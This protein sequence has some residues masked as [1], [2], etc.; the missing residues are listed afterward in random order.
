[1]IFNYLFFLFCGFMF[2][3][4]HFTGTT[5]NT[6][7]WGVLTIINRINMLRFEKDKS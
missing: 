2:M 7:F 5:D 3:Y 1:M 4:Y 6:L